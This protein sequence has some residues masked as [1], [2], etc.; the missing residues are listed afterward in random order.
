MDLQRG[1]FAVSY[2]A[3]LYP[4]AMPYHFDVEL[5]ANVFKYLNRQR[6]HIKPS[7]FGLG[8]FATKAIKS[9]SYIG[10]E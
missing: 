9:G 6:I 2:S 7:K 3:R 5:R 1:K 8:A 10:G 4:V